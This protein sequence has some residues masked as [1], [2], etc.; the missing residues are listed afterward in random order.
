M[1]HHSY[2]TATLVFSLSVLA[3][4]RVLS[5]PYSK[6]FSTSSG[7][8]MMFWCSEFNHSEVFFAQVQWNNKCW[9]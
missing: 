9:K 3:V 6:T 1:V 8:R 5:D 4:I 2:V 7:I